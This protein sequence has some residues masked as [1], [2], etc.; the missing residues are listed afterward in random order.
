MKYVQKFNNHEDFRNKYTSYNELVS[1]CYNNAHIH[2]GQVD[3]GY[4]NECFSIKIL[5]GENITITID[6]NPSLENAA[7]KKATTATYCDSVT[8]IITENA[9]A[10]TVTGNAGVMTISG[11]NSG[12]QIW[13]YTAGTAFR[14]YTTTVDDTTTQHGALHFNISGGKVSLQGNLMSI[15]ADNVNSMYCENNNQNIINTNTDW[16][17]MCRSMFEFSNITQTVISNGANASV[18]GNDIIVYINNLILP[19]KSVPTYVYY[20]MFFGCFAL[21]TV[22]Q[23]P[24]TTLGI[25]CYAGMFQCCTSLED[26]SYLILPSRA[27]SLYGYYCMFKSCNSLKYPVKEI[28]GNFDGINKAGDTNHQGLG[29]MFCDCVSLVKSPKIKLEKVGRYGCTY[30]FAHCRSLKSIDEISHTDYAYQYAFN[31]I[32]WGCTSLTYYPPLTGPFKSQHHWD[33][34]FRGCTSLE[35]APEIHIG[36][37]P[38]YTLYYAFQNC[39]KLTYIDASNITSIANT[40]AINYWVTNVKATGTFVMDERK[41]LVWPNTFSASRIPK[42]SNNHWKVVNQQGDPMT[43]TDGEGWHT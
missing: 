4:E 42:D 34:A 13:L 6:Y 40:A 19:I 21:K 37:I 22:P 18:N 3:N 31:K 5:S 14:P 28:I 25:Y 36:S 20:R 35:R 17:H 10:T 38:Q 39:S 26:V 30:M 8:G 41:P 7:I 1:L 2:F 12:D 9:N 15:L 24:A 27:I 16:S 33:Y 32:A 11:L 23:L 43:Y 29:Y